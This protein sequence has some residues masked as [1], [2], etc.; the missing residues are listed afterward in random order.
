MQPGD[1]SH[2]RFRRDNA[3]G[4]VFVVN[5]PWPAR[6][7][8]DILGGRHGMKKRQVMGA[9]KEMNLPPL[10][11]GDPAEKWMTGDFGG[12]SEFADRLFQP[13]DAG[14]RIFARRRL[15]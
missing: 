11:A 12:R 2:R 15:Q 8:A 5:I 4:E 14:D 9:V 13:I 1:S 6:V 3:S 7:I 10:V